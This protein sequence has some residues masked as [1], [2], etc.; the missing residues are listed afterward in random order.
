MKKLLMVLLLV[1][2]LACAG[3]GY[4]IFVLKPE[5]DAKKTSKA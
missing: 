4:Y 5:Q 3:G 2:G 1:L